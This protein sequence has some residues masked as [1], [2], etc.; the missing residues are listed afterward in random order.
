MVNCIVPEGI[1][2]YVQPIGAE[3]GKAW[4]NLQQ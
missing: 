3:L 2:G 4:P 1:L